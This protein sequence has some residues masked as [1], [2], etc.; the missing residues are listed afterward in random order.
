MLCGPKCASMVRDAPFVSLR[1]LV[2]VNVLHCNA[3]YPLPFSDDEGFI[4]K[5]D[6]DPV[7]G[8]FLVP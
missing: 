2:K 1:V 7:I 6:H 3:D 8:R 5:S 4:H